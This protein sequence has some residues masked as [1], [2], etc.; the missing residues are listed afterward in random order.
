M[1]KARVPETNSGIQG[2]ATVEIYDAFARNMRDRGY[3]PVKEYVSRGLAGG[4]GLEIGPGPGYVGLEWLRA[5]PDGSL[6]G[7]EISADMIRVAERNAR[8]YGLIDRTRY[9]EG[10]SMSMPFTDGSFDCVVL[11][12]LSPRVGKAGARLFGDRPRAETG[13][14]LLRD[15]SASRCR[16]PGAAFRS[17][18]RQTEGNPSVDS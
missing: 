14:H 18:G 10:N 1:T 9:V 3:L 11:E 15:R 5:C 4:V 7:L 16:A 17:H 6:T 13:R 8:E 12:W 2:T